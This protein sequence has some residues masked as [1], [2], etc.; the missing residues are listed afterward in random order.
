MKSVLPVCSLSPFVCVYFISSIVKFPLK[1]LV[2]KDE[3][4]GQN[5]RAANLERDMI[6]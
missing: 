1:K 5:S 6:Y 3:F 4:L 2:S